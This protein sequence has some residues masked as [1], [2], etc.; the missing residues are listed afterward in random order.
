MKVLRWMGD[1]CKAVIIFLGE[2]L[3]W[4]FMMLCLAIVALLSPGLLIEV[5]DEFREEL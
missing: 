3:A 2:R 1:A 4:C 5:L